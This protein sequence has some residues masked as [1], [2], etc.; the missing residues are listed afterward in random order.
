[1]QIPHDAMVVV[2]DGRKMLLFRNEG[3]EVYPKLEVVEHDEKPVPARE[4]M[5]TDEPG[6]MHD[7]GA[8]MNQRSGM[9]ETDF[10][11]L[12]EDRFAADTAEML[13][14]RALRNEFSKLIVVAPPRALGELRKHYHKEVEARIIGE[15][16]KDYANRPTDEIEQLIA[17]SETKGTA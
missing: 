13:K 5:A 10:H 7:Y 8:G 12:E 4:D 3:D 2:A 11:Q 1:M 15:I 16:A 17:G 6:T 9:E 14:K